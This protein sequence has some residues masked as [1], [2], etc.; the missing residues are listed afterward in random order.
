[1]EFEKENCNIMIQTES[2][3]LM[4]ISDMMNGSNVYY[5]Q[6]EYIE[7]LDHLIY[8]LETYENFHIKLISQMPDSNYTIYAKEDLGVITAKTSIPPVVLAINEINLTAA[9]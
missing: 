5:T 2:I 7:H 8:L 1:M 4:T 3:S 9:F 6:D